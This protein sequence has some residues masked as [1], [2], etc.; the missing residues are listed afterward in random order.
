MTQVMRSRLSYRKANTKKIHIVRFSIIKK[1][2]IKQI[3][4]KTTRTKYGI[5]T[6]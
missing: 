4:I 1:L 6:I 2:K 5:K 3:V